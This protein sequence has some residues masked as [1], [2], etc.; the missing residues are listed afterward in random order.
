MI[1]IVATIFHALGWFCIVAG[2]IFGALLLLGLVGVAGPFGLVG[3]PFAGA[4]IAGGVINSLSF[5]AVGAVLDTLDRI[6]HNTRPTH[7][8]HLR[9]VDRDDLDWSA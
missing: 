1:R 5:F 8:G 3:L 2:V 9:I 7:R 4:I 6:E